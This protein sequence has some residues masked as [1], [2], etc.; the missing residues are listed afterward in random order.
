MIESL[1]GWAV[2][3]LLAQG[4]AA[5]E[6]RWEPN[7]KDRVSARWSSSV[8][9]VLKSHRGVQ[10]EGRTLAEH[11]KSPEH[12]AAGG[13]GGCGTGP[14][15]SGLS[16]AAEAQSLMKEHRASW[17]CRQKITPRDLDS[18]R[19]LSRLRDCV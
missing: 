16:W 15:S 18:N 7:V 3:V 11:A 10:C 13:G 19:A 2:R 8:F 9:V 4:D 12:Q 17:G 5:L 6:E 14:C 1:V